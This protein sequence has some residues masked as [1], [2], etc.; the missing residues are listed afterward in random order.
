MKLVILKVRYENLDDYRYEIEDNKR[1]ID[2]Y[3]YSI[4]NSSVDIE[5]NLNDYSSKIAYNEISNSD[6]EVK[7]VRYNIK[8]TKSV[9]DKN[10]KSICISTKGY[11]QYKVYNCESGATTDDPRLVD[12]EV[13]PPPHVTTETVARSSQDAHATT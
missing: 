2:I 9:C 3:K 13:N 5:D 8:R 12:G 4:D 6:R 11:R 7:V 10:N 1:D